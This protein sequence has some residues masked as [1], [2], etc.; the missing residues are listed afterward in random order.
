MTIFGYLNGGIKELEKIN[1]DPYTFVK[2]DV[3]SIDKVSINSVNYDIVIKTSNSD[4]TSISYYQ[5]AKRPLEMTVK[6]K[7]L[8]ISDTTY[9]KNRTS[10]IN[11]FTLKDLLNLKRLGGDYNL[12]TIVITLP[13]GYT[14]KDLTANLTT[15]D[16]ELSNSSIV[17]SHITLKAGDLEADKTNFNN[18][19]IELTAGDLDATDVTFTGHNTVD[20]AVGDVQ[21][22][23]TDFTLSV[24]TQGDFSDKNITSDLKNSDQNTL[25]IT[26]NLGDI[27]IQ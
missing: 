3:D 5:M 12:Y 20:A 19:Q 23:L 22:T 11:F 27:S 13:K 9:F 8:T 18:S 24:T 10:N 7:E 25:N 1:T 26:S 4:K 2:Q 16:L 17:K 6:D 21:I 14:L 15:G